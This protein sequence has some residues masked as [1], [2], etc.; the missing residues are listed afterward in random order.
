[1][2]S[3]TRPRA[4]ERT[5]LVVT[6]SL[7]AL[8]SMG[9]D[10]GCAGAQDSDDVAQDR[11]FTH[12]WLYHHA[13]TNTTDVRATFRFGHELGTVLQLNAPSR[14][15]FQSPSGST[16]GSKELGFDPNWGWHHIQVTGVADGGALIYTNNDGKQT[17]TPTGTIPRIAFSGTISSI[18]RDVDTTIA[19]QGSPLEAGEDVEL[20]VASVANRLNVARFTANQ[21]RSQSVVLTPSGLSQLP[22]GPV[23]M[24]FKRHKNQRVDD[25]TRLTLSYETVDVSATLQ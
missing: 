22:P 19:W 20:F 8:S 15:A 4:P 2:L 11:I 6:L 17:T 5:L 24:A 18:A 10:G 21:A 25:R 12:I 3:P 7:L 16:S 1:M 14:A 13:K 9:A 23:L